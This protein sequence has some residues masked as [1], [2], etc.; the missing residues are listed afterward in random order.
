MVVHRN[1]PECHVNNCDR[2]WSVRTQSKLDC[3]Y[4]MFWTADPFCNQFLDWWYISLRWSIQWKDWIVVFKVKVMVTVQN[5][6]DCL[7]GW[8]LLN[9]WIIETKLSPALPQPVK[10]LAERCTDAPANSM[11]SSS[12]M[13]LLSMLWVL[14]KI[15]SHTS[16][17]KKTKMLKFQISQFYW[18]FSSD[19]AVKELV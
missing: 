10:F 11:F 2:P 13:H 18:L 16:A 5:V 17:K 6:N 1:K 7:S 19:M 12:V 15:L 4:H 9:H 8:Y 3:F 14:M